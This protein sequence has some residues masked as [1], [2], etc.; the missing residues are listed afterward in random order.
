MTMTTKPPAA[1]Y[2]DVAAAAAELGVATALLW[3]WHNAGALAIFADNDAALKGTRGRKRGRI[4]LAEWDRFK[5][6]R[7]V[8]VQP[9][10]DE[11]STTGQGR[12]RPPKGSKSDG[13]GIV[14]E[15]WRKAK[16]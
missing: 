16:R 2:I 3:H 12:G 13:L 14:G 1:A 7:T 15:G 10:R 8:V 6:A 4:A 11:A 5:R 9:K